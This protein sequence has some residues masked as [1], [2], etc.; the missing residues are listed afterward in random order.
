MHISYMAVVLAGKYSGIVNKSWASTN[1]L[2]LLELIGEHRRVDG[3]SEIQR[4][5]SLYSINK[6]TE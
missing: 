2:D 5:I 1:I 4:Y 3:Q 6:A